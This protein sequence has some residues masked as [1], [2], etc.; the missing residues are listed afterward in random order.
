M[1]IKFL[2]I[3]INKFRNFLIIEIENCKLYSHN[4]LSV[5]LQNCVFKFL[6][7]NHKFF[8]I[9]INENICSIIEK[10]NHFDIGL[11]VKCNNRIKRYLGKN[12]GFR[13]WYLDYIDL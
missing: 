3:E 9:E 13:M 11:I 5:K 6:L 2:I 1:N 4:V 8:V 7:D 10:L 12:I